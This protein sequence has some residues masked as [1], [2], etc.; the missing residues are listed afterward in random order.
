MSALMGWLTLGVAVLSALF[1][2]LG[3]WIGGRMAAKT[4]DRT[5][6]ATQTEE[7]QRAA[8]DRA[9][10]AA[11]ELA[12]LLLDARDDLIGDDGHLLPPTE[13][14][15]TL[16]R[17]QRDVAVRLPHIAGKGLDARITNLLEVLPIERRTVEAFVAGGT[18]VQARVSQ[19][20]A[21]DRIA[22]LEWVVTSLQDVAAGRP[23]PPDAPKPAGLD[24]AEASPW[25]P[26]ST[27]LPPRSPSDRRRTQVK[28]G[29]SPGGA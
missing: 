22:Y 18:G 14:A 28:R 6:R 9:R 17:L 16:R 25:V 24:D 3:A 10:T 15:R 27:D 29:A 13:I 12:G 19:R 23:V 26:P 11:I 2:L 4:A 1:A 21:H 8:E 20:L 7:R 5:L